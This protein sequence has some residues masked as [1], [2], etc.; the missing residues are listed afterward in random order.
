M[1]DTVFRVGWL[2][3]LAPFVCMCVWVGWSAGAAAAVHLWKINEVYSNADGTIQYIELTT[4]FDFQNIFSGTS[5]TSTNGTA[6]QSVTFN[7]NTSTATANKTYLIGTPGFAALNLVTPDFT[8]PAGFL[9]LTNGTVNF[10]SF[11]SATYTSLPTDGTTSL[12]R[13]SFVS[14]SIAT[15][16][17]NSPKNFAG[18]MGTIMSATVPGMPLNVAATRGNAQ[19]SIA[20]SPPS[21]DGGAAI[22]SYAAT[23]LPGPF[24][25]S[26]LTSPLLVT[27]L[28]NGVTYSCSVRASNSVGAGAPSAAA[29]VTPATVP[30]VPVIG[31]IIPGDAMAQV[32]FDAPLSNGGVAINQYTVRCNDGAMDF[33]INTAAPPATLVG[34]VNGVSHTCRVAAT[35]EVGSGAESAGVVVVPSATAAPVLLSAASRLVHTGVGTLDVPL[36]IFANVANASTDPRFAMAARQLVLDFNVAITSAGTV[37]VRDAMSASVGSA[38]SSIA[39]KTVTLDLQ[40]V[41]A[42]QRFTVRLED[43]N[44]VGASAEVALAFFVGDVNSSSRVSA[45]DISAIKARSSQAANAAHARFDLNTDGVV[46]SSDVSIAKSRSGMHLN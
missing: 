23:C 36:N 44:A 6:T 46:T 10:G 26:G 41:P 22:S 33:I 5:L 19:A 14:S 16:A 43:L 15:Q 32:R 31:S 9:Y 3:S 20:F 45:A 11:D 2:R 1:G 25:A 37:F 21:S 42:T 24:S 29:S 7:Q 17:V 8:I 28:G 30:G 34:L 35:N 40:G 18:Q 38:T 4:S 39:N 13:A 12:N 27:G